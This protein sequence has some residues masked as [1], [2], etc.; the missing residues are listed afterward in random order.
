MKYKFFIVVISLLI[1]MGAYAQKGI[2]SGTP[3]GQGEDSIRCRTNISLFVPYAN[4]KNFADAYPYWKA[5]YEECPASTINIY[6]HGVN[7]LGWQ[8]SQETDPAKIEALI[9]DMMKLYDDRVKYFG[10]DPRLRKDGIIARK[11]EKYNQLK[12]ENTDHQLL[13]K[14]LGEVIEEFKENTDALAITRYMFSSF[15]LMQNDID[16]LKEQYINDFLLCS[17]IFDALLAESEKAEKTEEVDNILALKAEMEQ[18]F[19]ASG[20]ADCDILQDIYTSKIEEN[21]DNLD[22]LKETMLLLRRMRCN[23]SD[24]FITASEYAYKIEPTADAAMGLGLKA[25]KDKDLATAEKY[26]LEAISMSDNSELKANLYYV[27]A[28]IALQQ[29]QFQ[30]VKQ[31][32][33]KCI[34]EK[35]NYGKAYLLIGQAYAAGARSIYPD[36]PVLSKCIYYAIIDKAERARQVDPSVADDAN[37]MI[38]TY[39]KY[40]PTKEEVFMH[41]SLEAGGS[42]TIGGWVNETIK[43]R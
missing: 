7:I 14:W 23:E 34:T 40:F 26:Y 24:L 18:N 5:V 30:K 22:F 11:A 12:G 17:D 1:A 42:F 37:K 9:N 36:D 20:A 32:C 2:D 3:F 10:N 29:N 31:L 16:N 28:G 38:N 43:I 27:L 8:I 21:K 41:P 35:S 33:M 19:Y 6:I 39:N 13:Y 15:K 4:S 25:A